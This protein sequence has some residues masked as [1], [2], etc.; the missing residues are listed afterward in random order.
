MLEFTRV[1]RMIGTVAIA[2]GLL[3]LTV[4][5]AVLIYTWSWHSGAMTATGTVV[6]HE[7]TTHSS[8]R[9]GSSSATYA[10]IVRFTDASGAQVEFRS[11]IATSYPFEVGATVPVVYTAADGSDATI[12][13]WFRLWGFPLIF[14][15]AGLLFTAVG[16]AF[17]GLGDRFG[18]LGA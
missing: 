7:T 16:F 2:V 15:G 6:A 1:P 3:E 5:V 11:R 9:R 14:V 12:D 17:R 4:A 18:R 13:S 10:E 8:S